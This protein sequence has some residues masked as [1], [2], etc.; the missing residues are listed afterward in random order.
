MYEGTDKGSATFGVV[1]GQENNMY[2][3]KTSCLLENGTPLGYHAASSGN[4][5]PRFWDNL[6]VP[7]SGVKNFLTPEDG[8][9]G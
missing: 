5:L 2:L 4:F 6:S 9:D 1:W 3:E 7:N 8:T